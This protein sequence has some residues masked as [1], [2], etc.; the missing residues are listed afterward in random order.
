[1]L[2]LDWLIFHDHLLLRDFGPNGIIFI[3]AR[4]G[5]TTAM[6]MLLRDSGPYEIILMCCYNNCHDSAVKEFWA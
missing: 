6:I 3:N 5:I 4:A 2:E 1:V